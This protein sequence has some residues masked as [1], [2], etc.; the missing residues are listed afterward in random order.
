MDIERLD[1][2]EVSRKKRKFYIFITCIFVALIISLSFYKFQALP[3]ADPQNLIIS[4][5]NKG[6]FVHSSKAAGL[7]VAKQKNILTSQTDALVNKVFIGIGSQV[8]KGDLLIELKSDGIDKQI[9]EREFDLEEA[10]AKQL[11]LLGDLLNREMELTSNLNDIISKIEIEEI[12]LQ[13]KEKLFSEN[14]I[15]QLDIF[16][17]RAEL[18]NLEKKL[19]FSKKI[20]SNFKDTQ[21]NKKQAEK[22]TINRIKEDIKRL[23]KIKSDL[24]VLASTDGIVSSIEIEVGQRITAGTIL[25]QIT[26]QENFN[27][28]LRVNESQS[29]LLAY[30]QPVKLKIL[31][32]TVKGKLT[33]I[34]PTVINNSVEIEVEILDK[35]PAGVRPDMSVTGEVVFNIMEDVLVISKPLG[36]S[37]GS[38]SELFKIDKNTNVA[39]KVLVQFGKTSVN[40][41]QINHGVKEGDLLIIDLGNPKLNKYNKIEVGT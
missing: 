2:L 16:K 37:D 9:I 12:A 31:E 27:A 25:A 18:K 35:L 40:Q 6:S 15:S 4:T 19:K 33:R 10:K 36:V 22:I 11:L 41:A 23:K 30:E 8:K 5:V 24:K 32:Q 17:A 39:T 1:R 7:L 38:Q 28:I 34:N 14:I 26:N 29:G 13:A 20:M 21:A 3:F